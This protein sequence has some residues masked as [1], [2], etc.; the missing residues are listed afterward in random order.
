MRNLF[1]ILPILA[2]FGVSFFLFLSSDDP[3]DDHTVALI[4]TV[5]I[6][7][8]VFLMSCGTMWIVSHVLRHPK[9]MQKM[10]ETL[11]PAEG[12]PADKSQNS[13]NVEEL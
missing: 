10:K 13:S 3:G 7:L 2:L 1:I 12:Q 4:L 8:A 9:A 6:M 11:G 5:V